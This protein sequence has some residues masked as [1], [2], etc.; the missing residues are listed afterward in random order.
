VNKTDQNGRRGTKGN[1]L[2]DVNP[3][4]GLLPKNWAKAMNRKI[5]SWMI[6]RGAEKDGELTRQKKGV[7]VLQKKKKSKVP[8]QK[9]KHSRRPA[10]VGKGLRTWV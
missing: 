3:K 9:R 2:E 7:T 6:L 8:V 4:V 1:A 10:F 5:S